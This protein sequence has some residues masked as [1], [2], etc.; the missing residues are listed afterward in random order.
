[1][2]LN[3]HNINKLLEFILSNVMKN[4]SDYVYLSTKILFL[5]IFN[6]LSNSSQ[7][8]GSSIEALNSIFFNDSPELTS[9]R[10]TS[11]LTFI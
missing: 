6:L 4:I 9:I 8:S 10:S 1:M 3:I 5:F 7:S 2:L 11:R